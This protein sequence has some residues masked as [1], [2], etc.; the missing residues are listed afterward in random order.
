MGKLGFYH[1]YTSYDR[2]SSHLKRQKSSRSNSNENFSYAE[3][4]I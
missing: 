2:L 4:R 3:Q 1:N